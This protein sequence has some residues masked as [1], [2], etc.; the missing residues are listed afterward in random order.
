MDLMVR[1]RYL[2]RMVL[3][4]EFIRELAR[5][6]RV[7]LILVQMVKLQNL[8]SGNKIMPKYIPI[9]VGFNHDCSQSDIHEIIWTSKSFLIKFIIPGD[10]Y[11][12]FNAL[13]NGETIIRIIDEEYISSE[14]DLGDSDGIIGGNILYRIKGSNFRASLPETFSI[15]NEP[16]E[17]YR[18]VT[19]G[20]CADVACKEAP[21]CSI[22][23]ISGLK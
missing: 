16:I 22:S 15:I 13:F 21:I 11:N 19:G 5:E 20:G 17:H 14:Q 3:F 10:D 2:Q 8:I 12:I 6:G 9:D 4:I 1:L 7:L 18:F 23:S